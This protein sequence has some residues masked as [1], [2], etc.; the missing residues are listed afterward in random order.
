MN[1]DITFL[2]DSSS[3]ITPLNFQKEKEFIKKLS[4]YLNVKPGASRAAFITFGS[5]SRTAFEYDDYQTQSQME[6]Q[7]DGAP[8]VGGSRV[9]LPALEKA[10][11]V[12]ALSRP[13]V[14]KI[15]VFVTSGR[16]FTISGEAPEKA[17]SSLHNAGANVFVVVV[18]KDP[19]KDDLLKMVSRPQNLISVYTFNQLGSSAP[20]I[21]KDIS[22][23][24]GK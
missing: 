12:M 22:S 11:S 24:S 20:S 4:K 7:I 16:S 23:S 2:V 8:Y 21:A 13:L 5:Q 6:T 10:L 14:P 9:M 15:I 17:I 3:A 1:A 18:R 19:D